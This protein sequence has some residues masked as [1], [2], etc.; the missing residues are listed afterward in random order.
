MRIQELIDCIF[1]SSDLKGGFILDVSSYLKATLG[2]RQF[3]MR[4]FCLLRCGNLFRFEGGSSHVG[5][6]HAIWSAYD[7]S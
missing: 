5:L 1:L 3:F 2:V 7:G 6:Q 4:L